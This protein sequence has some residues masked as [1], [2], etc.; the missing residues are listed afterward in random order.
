M[1]GTIVQFNS[2][3]DATGGSG[4]ATLPAATKAGN[5]L[6][7]AMTAISGPTVSGLTQDVTVTGSGVSH[8]TR[9]FRKDAVAGETSW[10]VSY[11]GNGGLWVVVEVSG[12]L[13][14]TGPDK[15]ASNAGSASGTSTPSGT[16]AATTQADEFAMAV[17]SALTIGGSTPSFSG[18]TNSFGEIAD[19]GSPA[20]ATYRN[21]LA[22]ATKALTATGTQTSTA[23]S[24][25]STYRSGLIATYKAALP[26]D[27]YIS[28]AGSDSN[29][30]TLA[31]PWKTFS[32]T[33]SK[34]FIPGDTI[35]LRGGDT[36][37]G[38]LY[39]PNAGSSG[40]PIKIR[41]YGTGRAT[42]TNTTN[43]AIYVYNSGYVEIDNINVVGGSGAWAYDGIA[44][45]ASG[46]GQK[47]YVRITNC[48][49]SWFRNG[50]AV[51]GDS[52][53]GWSDVIINSVDTHDCRDQGIF[54]YGP[55]ATKANT[56]VTVS[57]CRAWGNPGDSAN[58]TTH[59]GSGILLG[60]VDGGLIQDCSA[61]GNGANCSA[62]EGPVGIWCY[63]SNAVIIE[64]CLAYS[65]LTGGTADGDGFDL[66]IR[67]TNC[68]VR[69]CLAYGNDGAGILVY[70]GA[71]TAHSGNRVHHNICWGNSRKTDYYYA[72]LTLAGNVG[73]VAVFHNTL[74]ARDNGAVL[75]P[76]LSVEDTGASG[77]TVRNNILRGATGY[78]VRG[79]NAY[80]TT[81]VLL[82]GNAYEGSGGIRWG[83]TTHATLAALRA[84]VSGQEQV[85]GVNKGYEGTV[86]LA[87]PNTTPTITTVAGLT[88]ATDYALTAASPVKAAGLDLPTLFGVSL[89]SRDY[90]GTALTAPYSIGAHEQDSTGPEPGRR[91]L[92]ATS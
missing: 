54:T 70:G 57:N 27:Y 28:A 62:P 40:S 71:V 52:G 44:F 82:Q 39:L 64:R 63:D 41:S 47:T 35:N 61:W 74:I 3:G 36:F 89:G 68:E 80:A 15:T 11:G 18:Y 17:F 72:E 22:V 76:A 49:I 69:Y 37:S 46:A 75:P 34:T 8:L 12:L 1:P 90:F 5:V 85:S 23:T 10:P 81:A 79:E 67:T 30:G 58:T 73:N 50:I 42:I 16:T 86:G 56:N 7:I 60:S 31:A 24:S 20:G 59:T 2:G 91:L 26:A 9:L 51:G 29:P 14:G 6:F 55:S 32:P 33:Y 4:T 77:A 21:G 78:L 19:V 88:G 84:A 38:L 66:D 43:S 65:N 45:Y 25:V 13:T 87:S 53:G 48:E 83:G 92:S